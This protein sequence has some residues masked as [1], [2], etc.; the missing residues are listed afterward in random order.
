V[1]RISETKDGRNR[2]V[3]DGVDEEDSEEGTEVRG[4]DWVDGKA[5]GTGECLGVECA[6]A[7]GNAGEEK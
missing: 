7:P 3:K 1:G 5:V 6:K 2:D 4:D